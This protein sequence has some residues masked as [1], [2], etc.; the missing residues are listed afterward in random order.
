M[1]VAV[2]GDVHGQYE[3]LRRLNKRLPRSA[4][5]VFVGDLFDRGP[6]SREV[7]EFLRDLP[8]RRVRGNH[9]QQLLDVL[10]GREGDMGMECWLADNGGKATVNSF[11]ESFPAD[12]TEFLEAA[13]L[14]I[15][16]D[17]L[18]VVH[19]GIRPM[20]SLSRQD[21]FDLLWIRAEFYD[22]PDH[23]YPGT[24]VFGHTPL[25]RVWVGQR[26]VGCDTG[27]GAGHSLSAAIFE[28]GVFQEAISEAV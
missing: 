1:T 24:V 13:P 11:R 26:R 28:D 6:Q 14:Y 22:A 25:E 21:P 8:H 12:L 7:Y 19:A 20:V 9:D 3:T 23:G 27:A 10:H 16:I 4:E 17:G 15:E 2:I 18:L 5:R